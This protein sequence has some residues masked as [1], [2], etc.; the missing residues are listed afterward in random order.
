MFMF[1]SNIAITA[2]VV[3][4]SFGNTKIFNPLSNIYY[5]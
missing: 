3:G 2:I 1:M 4:Y 5:S